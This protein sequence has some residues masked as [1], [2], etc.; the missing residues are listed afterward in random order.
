MLVTLH[1][2]HHYARSTIIP[3]LMHGQHREGKGSSAT[4]SFWIAVLEQYG[5]TSTYHYIS[6]WPRHSCLCY[7]QL[8]AIVTHLKI[9]TPTMSSAIQPSTESLQS[10]GS[11]HLTTNQ[12]VSTQC[13][14]EPFSH[15]QTMYCLCGDNIDN[16]V[17][18]RYKRSDTHKTESIHYFHSYAV[19]NIQ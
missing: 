10:P 15:G 5:H 1:I 14:G 6:I 11:F 13:A 19:A 17:K 4:S 7:I 2:D 8:K 3:V 12:Q 9:Q 18:P 16:T